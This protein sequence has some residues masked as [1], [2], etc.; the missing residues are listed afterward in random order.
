MIDQEKRELPLVWSTDSMSTNTPKEEII[1]VS[2]K[3][4]CCKFCGSE[5]YIKYGIRNGKQ[6]YMCKDCNRKFVDNLYFERLKVDPKIICITLDLYFKGISLRKISDHLKQFYNLNVYFTTVF[7]WIDHYIRIMDEYV[8]QFKPNLG[9]I[10]NV[11]E[12]MLNIHGDWFYLWNVIDDETRFHLA[13]VVSK[14]RSIDDASKV[15]RTAKKRSHGKRPQF[16]ITDGLKSYAKAI[17]EEFHTTKRNTIH[18][19]NAGIKGKKNNEDYFDN[20]L[21]ERLHGTIRE[22]N[23]TQR[24]LK[25]EYSA[26]V[27]GHQLYYNFIKPHESLQGYTP[28][29]IAGIAIDGDNKWLTLMRTAIRNKNH[30][31]TLIE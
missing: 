20:N 4:F 12:M 15:L 23:K 17:D 6:N 29:E 13:S 27:R 5:N 18:I 28:A 9:E 8:R 19:G 30:K 16:I 22:R 11:D 26:F 10:W 25:D 21:V 1:E 31:N 3:P 7:R 24:G 14:N 2:D